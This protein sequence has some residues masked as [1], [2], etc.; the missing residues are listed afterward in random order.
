MDRQ[1]QRLALDVPQRQVHG[2]DGVD[3]FPARRIEPRDIHLLPEPLDVKRVLADQVSGT[4]L[5]RVPAPAFADS[6]DADIRLNR[7]DHIALVEEPVDVGRLVDIHFCDLGLGQ[8]SVQPQRPCQYGGWRDG[9]RLQKR[10]SEHYETP[11]SA[12]ICR[13]SCVSVGY[14]SLY[15]L[16]KSDEI[17]ASTRMPP[18]TSRKLLPCAFR[19]STAFCGLAGS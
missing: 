13:H 19:S 1:F 12:E 3:L 2:A 5:Q 16:T 7:Y 6:R 14:H 9:Q 18:T 17:A 8:C 4:L 15:F 11:F 10:P